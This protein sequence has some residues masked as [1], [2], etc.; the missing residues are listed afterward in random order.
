MR[1]ESGRKELYSII[2]HNIS[3]GNR[4]RY[5]NEEDGAGCTANVCL[6][7]DNDIYVANAGDSRTVASINHR[8]VP[9]SFDHKPEDKVEKRRIR[10]AGGF[11]NMGRINHALNMS[12]SLGDFAFK[13]NSKL[14]AAEQMITSTPDVIRCR[15]TGVDFII[16]GCDG[17]WGTKTN[18]QMV[19]W[20]QERLARKKEPADILG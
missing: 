5:I 19:E 3:Q 15:V 13:R 7:V 8:V 2:K 11:V 10:K 17:I 12:R 4:D 14:T 18:E 16:Q 6:I 9:L 20:I 1:S